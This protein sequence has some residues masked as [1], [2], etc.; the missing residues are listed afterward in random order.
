MLT[1]YSKDMS[2][3]HSAVVVTLVVDTRVQMSV[4]YTLQLADTFVDNTVIYITKFYNIR[5]VVCNCTATQD[6]DLH[7][8]CTISLYC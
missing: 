1:A 2:H 5:S 3:I 6:D 8:C 7:L 4:H